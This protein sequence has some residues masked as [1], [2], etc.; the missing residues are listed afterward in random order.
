MNRHAKG[1]LM[2]HG[3]LGRQEG[4]RARKTRKWLWNKEQWISQSMVIP[5]FLWYVLFCYVPMYGIVLGFKNYSARK[6]IMGSPWVGL[7]HFQ[8]LISDPDIPNILLNTVA[9]GFLKLLICFPI[10]ILFA[11]LINEIRSNKFK[12]FVQTVSYF[13]YFISWIIV[14]MIAQFWLN[15]RTGVLN[16]LLLS[17]GLIQEPTALLAQ[18]NAFWGIAVVTQVWK[19]TGWSA[20]IF[21][22]AIA[23]IDPAI[24]EAAIIDGASKTQR[25]LH[26]TLPSIMGT[27]ILMFLLN[28]AG[29][30]S[31]GT[32]T[33][34]QSYFLGNPRNYDRSYVLSYYVMKTGLQ[35][36]RF[37]YATAVGFLNAIVSFVILMA[38]NAVCKKATGRS[39]YMEGDY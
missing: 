39:L 16:H 26:V 30:F 12:R 36:G 19:E 33:F 21:L 37:S 8:E 13:P 17:L 18:A 22:A 31:G 32:G 6:G 5:G 3:S 23:G 29:V 35:Q 15:P 27:I 9:I 38:S 28:F 10:A 34:D 7:T 1:H 2:Q 24:Y 20:I 14:A 4:P 25:I 11:L